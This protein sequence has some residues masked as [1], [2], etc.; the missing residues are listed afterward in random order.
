MY[1]KQ[2]FI[3]DLRCARI[4]VGL[5]PILQP[6]YLWIL[7]IEIGFR[8]LRIL[9]CVWETRIHCQIEVRTLRN[10]TIYH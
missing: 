9:V 7:V 10:L 8:V 3:V 1:G 4:E 6:Q 5:H 2:E